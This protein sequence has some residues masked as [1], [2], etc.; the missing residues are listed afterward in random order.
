M[1]EGQSK[2]EKEVFPM[3][4]K[5]K[6][7]FIKIVLC[8]LLITVLLFTSAIGFLLC[9]GYG[10][11]FG[12]ILVADD[13][14]MLIVEETPVV[15]SD[16]RS[17]GVL[18]KLKTGDYVLVIHDGITDNYPAHTGAYFIVTLAH[19]TQEDLSQKTLDQLTDLGWI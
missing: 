6:M 10:A 1:D 18:E 13:Y 3:S 9:M 17:A 14:R 5:R 2:T 15:L 19:G 16:Q 12:R 7:R 4:V 11:S 8:S